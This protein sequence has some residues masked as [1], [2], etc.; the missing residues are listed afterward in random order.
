MIALKPIKKH[1][2]PTT[3]YSPLLASHYIQDGLGSI[4]NLVS[5]AQSVVNSY[6]YYG[7]GE[8]LS[9]SEQVSNRYRF[10]G[11]EWDNESSTYHYR[12]RQ[13][14]P[15]TGRFNRRDPLGVLVPWWQRLLF[16]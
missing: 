7:F 4:R 14:T 2:S 11:R 6:D 8:S 13:Y 16:S 12:A 9:A 15:T 5:S 10:T 3:V 1:N